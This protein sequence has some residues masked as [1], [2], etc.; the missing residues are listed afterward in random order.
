MTLSRFALRLS[1]VQSL[2]GRTLAGDQVRN[3]RIGAIDIAADGSLRVNED[4]V[5][6]DVFTDDSEASGAD[7][8]PRDLHENGEL[9]LNFESGITS[10]MTGTNDAGESVIVGVNVP[11]TDDAFEATLDIL[12]SQ[13]QTAL[14]DPNNEWAEV[15]RKLST[16]ILK[17]ERK[18]AASAD[19]GLRRAA[20]Q[21]RV[22]LRARPDPLPNE[23]LAATSPFKQF[24]DLVERDC[25]GMLPQVEMM[26][27]SSQTEVTVDM[28]RAAFGYTASEADALGF[29]LQ[30]E[31]PIQGFD[32]ADI[33]DEQPAT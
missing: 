22:T 26:I 25:P 24:R 29:A 31:A 14:S 10:T 13:I 1:A 33:D 18:R 30:S 21:L 17:V 6:L 27:G 12:D 5:F 7:V 11:A 15:W 2:K 19:D 8:F 32:V 20:R 28:I 9:A 23:L 4:R 3:S 16:G